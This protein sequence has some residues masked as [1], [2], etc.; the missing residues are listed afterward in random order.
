LLIL[1][2]ILIVGA[3]VLAP[4]LS[5]NRFKPQIEST[6]S[7]QLGRKV[8]VGSVHL[9]LSRGLALVIQDLTA[10]EDPAF[11][12]GDTIEAGTVKVGLAVNQL[13]TNRQIVPTS[14]QLEGAH[15]FFHRN[16]RGAWSWSTLGQSSGQ[17]GLGRHG[18]SS[19]SGSDSL[20]G[21]LLMQAGPKPAAALV[22]A[23]QSS[24]GLGTLKSIELK[25]ASVTFVEGEPDKSR[26]TMF[27]AIDLNADLSPRREPEPSTHAIGSLRVS[28][29]KTETTERLTAV[30]PFD[31]TAG[32]AEVGGF[33]ISGTA[34]PGDVQTSA[35]TARDFQS[36]VTVN[37]NIARFDDIQASFCEGELR[38]GVQLDLAALRPRFAVEGKLAGVNIDQ[39]VGTLFAIPGAMTGHISGDFKLIGLMADLPSSFPSITGDGQL[40]SDDLFL[41]RVNLSEQVARRLGVSQIGN[42]DPGT[43]VGHIDE[44]F[45]ISGGSITIRNLHLRQLDGL[46]D[47]TTDRATINVAFSS[48]RPDVNLD[49][50]TTVTLSQ[51]AAAAAKQASPLLGLAAPLLER[52][53]ALSV[54][55]HI[56]GDALS[57]H[58]LVDLPRI[59]Q[60]LGK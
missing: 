6:L 3:I 51:E 55:I 57:P 43:T 56:T 14:L 46:G 36:S 16:A 10:S 44:Q 42:M 2:V 25:H 47:A 27:D 49:F 48:G 5:L 15:L 30:M 29:E 22:S 9:S 53:G 19:V 37:G 54:P 1:M 34:G 33:T 41:S 21:A 7:N 58:V 45:G 24:S 11:A 18:A 38:G 59:L 13:I 17:T 26:Q 39:S 52:S 35:F 40:S 28:S 12:S 50:P 23:L 8:T 4:Y 32:V 60:S 31:V 20:G